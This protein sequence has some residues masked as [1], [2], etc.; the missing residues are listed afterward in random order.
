MSETC[1]HKRKNIY[2]SEYERVKSY[3]IDTC[4]SN[5]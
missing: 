2:N 5:I 1:V 3:N 4:I